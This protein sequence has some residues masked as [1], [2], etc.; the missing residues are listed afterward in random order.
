MGDGQDSTG[1]ASARLRA[2]TLPRVLRAF[3]PAAGIG[4]VM[5][6]AWLGELVFNHTAGI[7][8]RTGFAIATERYLA[9]LFWVFLGAMTAGAV[10]FV[11]DTI[12]GR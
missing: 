12:R 10:W 5:G 3:T 6:L 4:L 2:G 11:V 9:P 7:S 1:R 8:S